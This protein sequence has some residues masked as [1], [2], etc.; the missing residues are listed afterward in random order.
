MNKYIRRIFYCQIFV[1][2]AFLLQPFAYSA[3]SLPEAW[4]NYLTQPNAKQAQLAFKKALQTDNKNPQLWT[5]LAVTEK[6]LGN[7]DAAFNATLSALDHGRYD[8]IA[9]VY[10]SR[11]FELKFYCRNPKQLTTLCESIINDS[12]CT[13][14]FRSVTHWYLSFLYREEGQ[15][16]LAR[17]EIQQL[18]FV[19][20]YL[21]IGPFDNEGKVGFN[22]AYP[23]EK[24]ISLDTSYQGKLVDAKWLRPAAKPD[25]GIINLGN[26]LRPSE[27]V[28]G[29]I[30]TYV[31][32][33]TS[34]AAALRL[35]GSALQV[36]V[37]DKNTWSNPAIRQ[38]KFDQ[39]PIPVILAQGWNQILVKS[40]ILTGGWE[41]YIR[42]TDPEGNKIPELKYSVDT[43]IISSYK[44]SNVTELT[45]KVE[46]K[47][48]AIGTILTLEKECKDDPTNALAYSDLAYLYTLR[49]VHDENSQ[50]NILTIETALSLYPKSTYFA[51][52]YADCQPDDNL[53]RQKI[54]A[55]WDTDSSDVELLNRLG[56]LDTKAGLSDSA[57]KKYQKTLQLNPDFGLGDYNLGNESRGRGWDEEAAIYFS[58]VTEIYPFLPEGYYQL[59]N[60]PL[61]DL[62]QEKKIQLL[63]QTLAVDGYFDP[64]LD[65]LMEFYLNEGDYKKFNEL[66]NHKLALNPFD[67][68]VYQKLA[69]V[70][71]QQDD[72]DNA[73]Q[74]CN[75][76]L[77]ISPLDPSLLKEKGLIYHKEGKTDEAKKVWE[78]GLESKPNDEWLTEYLSF[79]A[80]ESEKYYYPYRVT[81]DQAKLFSLDSVDIS[82]ANTVYLL[83]QQVNKVYDDGNASHYHHTIVKA[84]TE[85]GVRQLVSQTI[86]Y[87]PN[88]E[89]VEV[90]KCQVIKPDG[91]VVDG[92]EAGEFSASDVGSRLYYDYLVK[93]YSFPGLEKGG[94]I[95][96]EY[97]I[98][99]THN[100]LYADYF[101]DMFTVGNYDP[102]V[103]SDY[104]LITPTSRKFYFYQ[105]RTELK[106]VIEDSPTV[107]T[108][109]YIWRFV[110]LPY[111]EQEPYMPSVSEIL[112]YIKVSS[113]SKWDEVAQ[114]YWNLIQDQFTCPD[115]LKEM[116]QSLTKDKKTK[117]DKIKALYDFTVTDV[118]YLGLEFGASGY[119]PHNAMDV[120]RSRYG[121]CKDKATL[122]ITMLKEIGIP[123]D[124]VLVR[125]R[126]LGKVDYSLPSLG[127]FDHAI[128]HAPDVDGHEVWLD[129]TAMYC[130]LSEFPAGDQ[131]IQVFCINSSR[132]KFETTPA[133]TADQSAVTYK[134][135]VELQPDGSATG[136][137]TTQVVGEFAPSMRYYFANPAK[138]KQDVER[139]FNSQFPGTKI[140]EP[141]HS[142]FNDLDLPPHLSFTF[143]IPQMAAKTGDKLQISG[144]VFPTHMT[145]S[146]ARRSDRIHP[147]EFPLVWTRRI[148]TVYQIP[149]GYKVDYLPAKTEEKH[150]FGNFSSEYSLE[151]NQL[152]YSQEIQM[153]TTELSPENYSQFRAWC[154]LIDRKED[155]KIFLTPAK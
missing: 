153:T 15:M 5:G 69:N 133:F 82:E 88:Q 150:P 74:E 124:I 38:G 19:T 113:F 92:K 102:T 134:T 93:Q 32:S 60:V 155:E 117:M 52:V 89:K 36:W 98:D 136:T 4:Q 87:S 110:N 112:P 83:D 30:L 24:E 42:V 12:K 131:N 51:K 46:K 25:W 14:Y 143:S 122:L 152:T 85:D 26:I 62:S 56:D 9:E 70:A 3:T 103:K 22:T 23:P 37:N 147:M 71:Y 6:A 140:G 29:Y 137:R 13:P 75:K 44:K 127:L 33:P 97:K 84:L 49:K 100:N 2:V 125:T 73:M 118:R 129:G 123:A 128:A 72:F 1:I 76:G 149:D 57:V 81:F 106:P 135:E 144:A 79:L 154:N 50:E 104:I 142:D 39:E 139:Q 27:K 99:E 145:D 114:W 54:E 108:R 20:D 31:Y 17:K 151:K 7:Y 48:V 80:P 141:E 115:D 64:A 105:D 132:G 109:T 65:Q 138:I 94:Y 146:Y 16:E 66:A 18:G 21:V 120:F 86:S 130:A 28:T 119:K 126:D 116:V 47:E 111:V 148:N 91:T 95:N 53:R 77:A 61:P 40:G 68:S 41:V 90:I 63:E 34:Q 43:E 11:A 55:A 10:L 121:D 45:S 107:S 96:F 58:K 8:P 67:L 35:G 78:L 101:G 59:A